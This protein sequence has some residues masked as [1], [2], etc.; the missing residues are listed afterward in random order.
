MSRLKPSARMEATAASFYR[1]L[2]SKRWKAA[3]QAYREH[4]APSAKMLSELVKLTASSSSSASRERVAV[5]KALWKDRPDHVKLDPPLASS[6]ISAFGGSLNL[7]LARTALDAA[8]AEQVAN[9]HV[10]NSFLKACSKIASSPSAKPTLARGALAEGERLLDAMRGTPKEGI[11]GF[12]CSVAVG[13][14]SRAG[15]LD[16]AVALVDDMGDQADT[17]SYNALIDAVANARDVPL[18]RSLLERMESGRGPPPDVRSYNGVLKALTL[19]SSAEEQQEQEEVDRG[20][21]RGEDWIAEALEVRRR[22]AAAGFEE[23]DVTRTLLLALFADSP[24]SAD[25]LDGAPSFNLLSREQQQ[26]QQQQQQQRQQQQQQDEG[27]QRDM[28]LRTDLR[29]LTRQAVVLRLSEELRRSTTMLEEGL[30]GAT[31]E[32]AKRWRWEIVTGIGIEHE[33]GRDGVSKRHAAAAAAATGKAVTLRSAL[34]WMEAEG[35]AVQQHGPGRLVV[36]GDEFHGAVLGAAARSQKQAMRQ[37]MLLRVGVVASGL[38]AISVVPRL[39][40]MAAAMG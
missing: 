33:G 31:A 12:T 27:Q 18:A 2:R 26:Q 15:K 13:L 9:T 17:V 11:D 38:A 36:S 35:I 32:E 37:G 1:L 25:V 14:L 16:E 34:E 19:A 40:A 20:G 28:T 3:H 30:L 7:G 4:E 5:L 29:G 21:G 10:R 8:E 24:L 6:F 23:N 22:M 39:I